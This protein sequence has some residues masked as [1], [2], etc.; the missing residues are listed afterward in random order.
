VYEGRWWTTERDAYD[1][2][3]DVTQERVTGEVSLRLYKGTVAVASRR[4]AYALYDE[5]FVTFGADEVYNQ[6]DAEGY[7]RLFGLSTRVQ[8]LRDRER[9]A[10]EERAAAARLAVA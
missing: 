7:I 2:F 10:E 5:R 4:S 8:A 3:V 9:Q 1:A 6:A